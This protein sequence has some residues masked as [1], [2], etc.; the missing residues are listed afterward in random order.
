LKLEN[1][2][3]PLVAVHGERSFPE[4]A[5]PAPE[6]VLPVPRGQAASM[7][8]V[9]GLPFVGFAVAV[10]LL[11][12]LAVGWVDI[13]LFV[14]LYTACALGITVGFHRMLTH[15]AFRA[16]PAVRL[17]LLGLGSMAIQGRAIEWAVDHRT[18]HAH[19][20]QQGDPHSPH[21]GF[22]AGHWGQLRGLVHAHVGWMFH[23]RRVADQRRWAKDLTE[24]PVIRLVDR[25]FPVWAVLG[26]VL[27]FAIGGLVT[28]SWRG[29]LTGLLW[30]GLA[31]VFVGHHV[32][33]SIN[34]ICHVFGRRPF[35]SSDQS[36]NNWLLALPS[37]GE[38][39]H[40]NHHV[41]PSSAVHGLERHQLD[42]S[43]ALIRGLERLGL[44]TDVRRVTPEQRARKRARP[45]VAPVESRP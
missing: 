11:W 38:S 16:R 41:F 10:W 23:H 40:H 18:H 14:V 12:N 8:L 17:V 43:A 28:A 29:A 6:A 22:A 24:D 13:G 39:W 36:R 30:G 19:S 26:L 33:W 5:R 32:T 2:D 7:L 37:L 20:D 15:R 35:V 45:G 27:P 34:S 25:T 1:R 44:V 42:L 31:R 3:A 9:V 4:P 21:A